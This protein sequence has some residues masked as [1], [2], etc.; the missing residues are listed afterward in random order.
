MSLRLV[1]NISVSL[2]KYPLISCL[3]VGEQNKEGKLDLTIQLVDFHQKPQSLLYLVFSGS[4]T[5][6]VSIENNSLDPCL[7]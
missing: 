4:D 6:S 1:W 5:S 7:G 3:A 2:E